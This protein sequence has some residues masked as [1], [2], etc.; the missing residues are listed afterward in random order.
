LN[1]H[2]SQPVVRRSAHDARR[3]AIHRRT[4]PKIARS[5]RTTV[6]AGSTAATSSS[7]TVAAS[8]PST[9]S[10]PRSS[11]AEAFDVGKGRTRW[12][13]DPI[14]VVR[15]PVSGARSATSSGF[16]IGPSSRTRRGR[17]EGVVRADGSYRV[18]Q[19]SGWEPTWTTSRS[20]SGSTSWRTKEHELWEAESR[21]EASEAERERL[22]ELQVTL[23]Q[24][25]GPPA[26]AP[27][28]A[29]AR[30]WTRTRRSVRDAREVE[31]Y[32]G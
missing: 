21:G 16:D 2:W 6:S 17:D 1:A 22:K 20:S 25:W 30:G 27:G 3:R 9:G 32:T 14:A 8:A 23:D 4:K 28:A 24:C 10:G 13:D 19:T 31:G 11:C 12:S 7:S 26:P 29:Q 5:G 15:H 18:S